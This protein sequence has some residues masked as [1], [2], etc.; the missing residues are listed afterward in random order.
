M[1]GVRL[2]AQACLHLTVGPRIL[3]ITQAGAQQ[4]GD[5]LCVLSPV[6]VDDD[7]AQSP[8]TVTPQQCHQRLVRVP[9]R[10]HGE[11]QVVRNG[12]WPSEHGLLGHAQVPGHVEGSAACG[13]GCKAQEAVDAHL[14][15]QRLTD[16][17]VT[18]PEVVG[19]LREAVGLIE[20]GK[21]DRRQLREEGAGPGP[22]QCL[23]GQHQH[24]H[25]GRTS[26]LQGRVP[27]LLGHP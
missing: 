4:G 10:G 6:A 25:A 21:G 18:R 15:P 22:D 24:L 5:T 8:E 7:G 17:Q 1:L 19:P 27:L 16:T 11:V 2:R 20:A 14:V 26:L 12:S 9:V 23:W 13:R 3:G